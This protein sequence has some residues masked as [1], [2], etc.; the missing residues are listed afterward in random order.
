MKQPI[1]IETTKEVFYAIYDKHKDSFGVFSTISRPDGG[2]FGQPEMMTEWGFKNS[3]TPIIKSVAEKDN[4]EDEW[5]WEYYIL[6]DIKV[7]E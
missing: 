6:F 1:F 3:D 5:K 4:P 7:H 2:Y